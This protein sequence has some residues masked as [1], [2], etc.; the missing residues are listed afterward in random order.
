M[1]SE[2][3]H[4]AIRICLRVADATAKTPSSIAMSCYDCDEPIWVDQ[5]MQIPDGVTEDRP[6][7][8][9]CGFLNPEIAGQMNTLVDELLTLD[10][11]AIA[12]RLRQLRQ[13]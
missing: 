5:L 13:P 6:T 4:V 1:G 2:E 3:G 10:D 12:D 9:Q 8:F 7:C 11:E